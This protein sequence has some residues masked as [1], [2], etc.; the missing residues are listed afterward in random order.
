ML[1]S[2]DSFTYM[3]ARNGIVDTFTSFW[4]CQEKTIKEQYDLGVRMFDIRVNK[5]IQNGKFTWQ[6]SHGLAKFNQN[7]VSLN[8]I[9]SYFKKQ[10]PD[11]YFRVVLESGSDDEET[12][13]KFKEQAK[14]LMTSYKAMVWQVVIKLPWTVLYRGK[15]F[16]EVNDYCCHLFNWNVDHD[17]WWNIKHF[18]ELDFSAY[19]IKAWA[20]KHNPTVTQEMKD[21]PDKLYFMDYVNI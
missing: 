4:R 3:V 16:K 5:D 17:I 15:D 6:V 1:G 7:F 10:Y 11:S 21:D 18:N 19:S 9:G 14:K 8:A 2:H 12:V 20:K 13:T